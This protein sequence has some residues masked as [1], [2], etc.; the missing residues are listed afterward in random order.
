M[1]SNDEEIKAG[2]PLA[3][4]PLAAEARRKV[5][6]KQ[7]HRPGDDYF[8]FAKNLARAC[9]QAAADDDAGTLGGLI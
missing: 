3:G 4:D 5:R 2:D 9:W 7:R 6:A 1:G 8:A